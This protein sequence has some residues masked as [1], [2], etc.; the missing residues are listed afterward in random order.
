MNGVHTQGENIADN[1]ATKQSYRAYKRW[2]KLHGKE[3]K[4]PGLPYSTE[5]MFWISAAQIWCAYDRPEFMKVKIRTDSHALEQFRV[6]GS[7][8]NND[9][10]ARDFNC[11]VGSP[12]NPTNKCEVW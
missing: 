1:G 10:F 5:Q 3:T 4:L 9:D 8:G 6:I 11:P 2:E 7:L 12:M